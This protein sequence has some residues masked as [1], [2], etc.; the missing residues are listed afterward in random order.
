[1]IAY[2]VTQRTRE[3]G[4][5]LALGAPPGAVVRRIA[6]GGL[7]LAGVGVLVGTAAA[8]AATGVLR[9]MLYA[10]GPADPLTF[11]LTALLVTGI[12]LVASY[13]PARRALRV[14]PAETLRAD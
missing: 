1:M 6:A 3:I 11:A 9:G 4:V 7:R 12:A 2:G 13:V 14:D 8:A 10:V 5:R